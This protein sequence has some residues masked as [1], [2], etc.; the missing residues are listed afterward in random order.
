M[1][2]V[3]YDSAAHYQCFRLA[4]QYGRSIVILREDVRG[5]HAGRAKVGIVVES[6]VLPRA[7]KTLSASIRRLS[8]RGHNSYDSVGG[9]PT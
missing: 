5:Q 6:H 2:N 7:S 3:C 8:H 4:E 1:G 9:F